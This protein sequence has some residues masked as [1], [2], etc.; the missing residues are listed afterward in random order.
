MC[1]V[2]I[3]LPMLGMKHPKITGSQKVN[4]ACGAMLASLEPITTLMINQS[5]LIVWV[6]V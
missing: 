4:L 6:P 1:I 5:N 3:V 2:S